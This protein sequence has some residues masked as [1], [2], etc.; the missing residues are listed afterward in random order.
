[1]K[2]GKELPLKNCDLNPIEDHYNL[3]QEA[4]ISGTPTF[5]TENGFKIPGLVEADELIQYFR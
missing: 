5:V 4:G 1:M 2:L 3:A